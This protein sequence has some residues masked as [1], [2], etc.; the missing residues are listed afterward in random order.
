MF[1]KEN[2]NVTIL[3]A[4]ANDDERTLAVLQYLT[5][6]GRT[7]SEISNARFIPREVFLENFEKSRSG[8]KRIHDIRAWA[9]SQDLL[10]SNGKMIF[11]DDKAPRNCCGRVTEMDYPCFI[12]SWDLPESLRIFEEHKQHPSIDRVH[13][14]PRDAELMQQVIQT[15]LKK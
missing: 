14:P 2:G 6:E 3:L 4:S 10:T 7:L 8:K 9:E 5:Y 11:L 13:V 15:F 12:T 1:N